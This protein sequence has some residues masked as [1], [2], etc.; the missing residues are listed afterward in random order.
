MDIQGNKIDVSQDSLRKKVTERTSDH[1]KKDR[2]IWYQA[3]I[4]KRSKV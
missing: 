4:G 3:T 2:E 1:Q